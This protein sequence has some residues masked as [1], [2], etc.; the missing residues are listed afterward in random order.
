MKMKRALVLIAVA[1]LAERPAS[2]AERP[3]SPGANGRPFF[4]APVPL[5]A[6]CV[7]LSGNSYLSQFAP[8][9][10]PAFAKAIVESFSADPGAWKTGSLPV[11]GMCHVALGKYAEA[12]GI[13][14]R[15][16]ASCP[17]AADS[18]FVLAELLALHENADSSERALEWLGRIGPPD[19]GTWRVSYMKLT[20]SASSTN[21]TRTAS[22]AL[23]A[24]SSDDERTVWYSVVP[25]LRF[26]R[27]ATD[28]ESARKVFE[29]VEAVLR[30]KPEWILYLPKEMQEKGILELTLKFVPDSV[31]PPDENAP[32][33]K[34]DAP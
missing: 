7:E 27:E 18:A 2:A 17:D 13:F 26:C 31:A 25:S 22:A 12:E 30:C 16:L 28:A 14:E 9:G 10:E 24:L 15:H 5:P 34:S 4:L 21:D 23:Q 19:S 33:P 32:A 20:A 6:T 1:L 8:F 29:A 11:V 3:G